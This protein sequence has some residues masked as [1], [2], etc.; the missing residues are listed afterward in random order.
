MLQEAI[1][2]SFRNVKVIIPKEAASAVLRGAVCYGYNPIAI[3]QRVLKY[4]YGIRGM[5]PF[6]EGIHPQ[7][8]NF[9]TAKGPYCD[10]I[11]YK[12]V[13][14]AQ[15]IVVGDTNAE[16]KFKPA[17]HDQRVMHLRFYASES[18][19]P[20]FVD[21]PGCENIGE[22]DLDISHVPGDLDGAV[23]VSFTFSNTENYATAQLEGTGEKVSASLNFLG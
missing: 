18:K 9:S 19:D 22:L 5:V 1:K 13:E 12:H 7:S 3:S 14:K 21:E 23:Y 6:R 4:T 11:F 17:F 2:Q 20:V 10:N 16:T 8:K 15:A